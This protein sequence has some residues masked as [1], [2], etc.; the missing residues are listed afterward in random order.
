MN[1]QI[2]LIGDF[3]VAEKTS[4]IYREVVL[5]YDDYLWRGT[6]PKKLRYQGLDLTESDFKEFALRWYDELNPENKK[7]WID[8]TVKSIPKDKFNNQTYLVLQAL[9]SGEWEC[10]VCGPVPQINPQAAS[11]LRDLKKRGFII[12]SKRKAC[13]KCGGSKM[14]DILIMISKIE[15]KLND[16]NEFRKPISKKVSE[17]IINTLDRVDVFFYVRR[18]PVEFVIDHKF[19]SQRWT[20]PES[21]NSLTMT[22]EQIE[23]KFQLLTNQSNMLK[24]RSCDRC[25]ANGLRGNFMGITH[26]YEGDEYWKGKSKDDESGCVGCPWY[27][28]KAWKESVQKKLNK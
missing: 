13:A 7:A 10:R 11:R 24:S 16:G 18:L 2:K 12:S 23:S 21:D 26:F 9:F 5:Q 8:S 22:K 3:Y 25:V 19:P 15:S 17:N 27:D 6:L 20:S 28:L 1:G 4:D 14:H